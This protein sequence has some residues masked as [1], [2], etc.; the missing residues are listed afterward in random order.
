MS[1]KATFPGSLSVEG[2]YMNHQSITSL[3]Y[4]FSEAYAASPEGNSTPVSPW[5]GICHSCWPAP[6]VLRGRAQWEGGFPA[7]LFELECYGDKGSK[8]V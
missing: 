7:R 5:G 3:G 8:E 1:R 6:G 2:V 4:D